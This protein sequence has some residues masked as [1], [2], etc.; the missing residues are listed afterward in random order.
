MET[1]KKLGANKLKLITAITKKMTV[2]VT[3][4]QKEKPK[5]EFA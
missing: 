4:L 1:N 5:K 3:E 2:M